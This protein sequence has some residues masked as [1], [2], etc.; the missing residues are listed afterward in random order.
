MLDRIFFYYFIY[1]K[2][3]FLHTNN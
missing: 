1:K 3:G 2:R